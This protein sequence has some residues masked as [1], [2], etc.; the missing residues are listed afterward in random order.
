MKCARYPCA[1]FQE[2]VK[3]VFFA[4]DWMGYDSVEEYLELSFSVFNDFGV[5]FC[6]GLFCSN[7]G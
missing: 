5:V 3:Q 7:V 6:F 4:E 1:W 2:P